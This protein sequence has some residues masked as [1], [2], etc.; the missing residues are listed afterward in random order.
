MMIA[1]LPVSLARFSARLDIERLG[2]CEALVG[3]D[4]EA[5]GDDRVSV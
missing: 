5:G 1:M 4:A 2:L 3:Y